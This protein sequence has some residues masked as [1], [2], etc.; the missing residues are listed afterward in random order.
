MKEKPKIFMSYY[1]GPDKKIPII[2][3]VCALYPGGKSK[4]PKVPN[5]FT[6]VLQGKN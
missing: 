6:T 1:G 5:L 2:I 4:N 3:K